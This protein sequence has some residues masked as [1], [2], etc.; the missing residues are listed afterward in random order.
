MAFN[1]G[2]TSASTNTPAPAGGGFS[3]GSPAAAP[4]TTT[5]AP[6]TTGFSFGAASGASTSSSAPLFGATPAPA[7]GPAMA[8]APSTSGSVFGGFGTPGSSQQQQQQQNIQHQQ[9]PISASTPYSSLPDNAK[10]MIDTIHELMMRHRRTMASV[11]TMSPALL[12][13]S[14]SSAS[15]TTSASVSILPP[16]SPADKAAGPQIQPP[17]HPSST[18]KIDA[19][20]HSSSTSY[21]NLLST[22]PLPVQI[23]ELHSQ[24]SQLQSDLAHHLSTAQS[25]QNRSTQIYHQTLSCAAWP[26]EALAARR[27][28]TLT[29]IPPHPNNT[30]NDK[31]NNNNNV[32]NEMER[33]LTQLLATQ[34]NAVDRIEALPSPFLWDTIHDLEHRLQQLQEGVD[35]LYRE[36]RVLHL[37]KQET[38]NLETGESGDKRVDISSALRSQTDAFLRIAALVGKVHE[39]LEVVRLEY[40]RRILSGAMP[41]RYLSRG[42]TTSAGMGM[43]MGMGEDPF[44]RADRLEEEEERKMQEEVRRVVVAAAAIA[45]TPPAASAPTTLNNPNSANAS[46]GLFGATPA[47]ATGGGLFGAPAPS[48]ATGGLFGAPAPAPTA[49]GLFGAT[50]APA[51]ATGG[52]FGAPAPAPTTGG[53]FGA[54]APAPATGGLFGAPAPAPATGGLFGATPAPASGGLFGAAPAPSTSTSSSTTR[55][56]T[57]RGKGRR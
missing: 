32:K 19:S 51:P 29:P 7:T 28:V 23:S 8:A 55:S 44:V 6:A 40:R 36:L 35:A 41:H 25:L 49:G 10:Q 34:A 52:L 16:Q 30:Q 21:S 2:G 48:P 1:F 15:S 37:G 31:G 12:A 22:S 17:P 38:P 5:A 20:E 43:E 9:Q 14:A 3:F 42:S 56:K 54:P 50:P 24:L 53:L 4:T 33:K 11:A 39:D 57:R 18:A 27:G 46:G 47:P 45:P 13:P 26:L